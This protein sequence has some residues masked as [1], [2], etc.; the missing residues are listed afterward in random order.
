[1]EEEHRVEE[2]VDDHD[3]NPDEGDALGGTLAFGRSLGAPS[4]G[5]KAIKETEGEVEFVFA[6]DLSGHELFVLAE[7][8]LVFV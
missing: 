3:D 2:F 5:Y 7:L 6:D 8:E 1:M 4:R